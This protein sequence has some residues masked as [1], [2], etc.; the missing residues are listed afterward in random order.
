M[1]GGDFPREGHGK[2][3]RDGKIKR[4]QAMAGGGE[5]EGRRDGLEAKLR[6]K[7]EG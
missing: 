5:G 4:L 1:K 3:V 7:M 6:E 2:R